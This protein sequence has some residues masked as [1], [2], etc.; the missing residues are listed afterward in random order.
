[1][2]SLLSAS[3]LDWKSRYRAYAYEWSY[4]KRR[5]SKSEHIASTP[6]YG[7]RACRPLEGIVLQQPTLLCNGLLSPHGFCT[8][9]QLGGPY[10][11]GSLMER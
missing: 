9:Y 11:T 8:V 5:N 7:I 2:N 10:Q 3:G 1:M 4:Q 6:S